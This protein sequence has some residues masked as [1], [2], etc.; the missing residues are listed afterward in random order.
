MPSRFDAIIRGATV[1]DGTGARPVVAD[2]AV[3][4]DRIAVVGELGGSVASMEIPASHLAVAPGFIDVHT[5]DDQ[6]LLSMP[7]MTC[8]VTQGVTTVI[9]GN[10]G[11]SLPPL[12]RAN[13]P[14]PLDII[15][16]DSRFRYAHFSEY[17]DALER[18]P[19]ALN[20]ALM[21][22][23]MTLRVCV[24]RDTSR[25]A[26]ELEIEGMRRHVREAL[27]CGVI[28]LSTG[29]FYPPSNAASADEVG[30]ILEE[31]RGTGAVY[32]THLRDEADGI[33]CSLDEAFDTAYR[34]QVPVI[35]SHHKC[36]GAR[37]FG[38]SAATLSKFDAARK[39]QS[40]GLDAY[41][42]TAGSTA[43]L[44]KLVNESWR[45]VVSWSKPY[46]D[47]A[48]RDLASIADA[49]GVSQEQAISR[50]EPGGGIYFVMDEADVERILK[51]PQTMIGS[52]GLPQDEFPHPR[53]WGTFPRI[54][55]HYSRVRGLFPLEEAIRRMTGLPAERFGLRDRGT[56]RAGNYADLVVFD[57][58]TVIDNATFEN[59]TRPAS[60]IHSVL[61]NGIPVLQDGKSTGSR[62]GRIIRR[63][64]LTARA[65]AG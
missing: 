58:A 20:A 62:P 25:A 61:V 52:D 47:F 64:P 59:P 6:A 46:P 28:G 26:N 63:S 40:V 12:I 45:I 60:G 16:Q 54:L 56:I 21:I 43:L 3:N 34:A 49:W 18:T 13:P 2:V 48:G 22:G 31:L 44:A 29:L 17:V 27:S 30:A 7:D 19:A 57:P 33:E 65:P 15:G 5:H 14:P 38:R 11:I 24:M 35:V 55:G 9:T 36:S 42:Y 39:R 23:H 10:C 41:P 50:L 8:K 4:G 32:T 1:F 51:Y 37:N 53:L